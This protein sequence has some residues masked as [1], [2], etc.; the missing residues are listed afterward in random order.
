MAVTHGMCHVLTLPIFL[1]KN[2]WARL[3]AAAN[4]LGLAGSHRFTISLAVNK[5][6]NPRC[7]PSPSIC[8]NTVQN[9][10]EHILSVYIFD[11]LP[12]LPSQCDNTLAISTSISKSVRSSLTS[13][14]KTTSSALWR[15]NFLFGSGAAIM[16]PCPAPKSPLHASS[17]YRAML[18]IKIKTW[19]LN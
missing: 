10:P 5:A 19:R 13:R 15:L 1:G 3:R 7:S 18:K 9:R 17:T 14:L 16:E 4:E 12:T 2:F 8:P 6:W 11:S